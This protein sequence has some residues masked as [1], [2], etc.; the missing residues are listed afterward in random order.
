MSWSWSRQHTCVP[1]GGQRL[2]VR[3]GH[4]QGWSQ[5]GTGAGYLNHSARER[6]GQLD[7]YITSHMRVYQGLSL[8]TAEKR[9]WGKG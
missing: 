3:P 5:P 8:L 9:H 7:R 6:V 1:V 4:P 2:H